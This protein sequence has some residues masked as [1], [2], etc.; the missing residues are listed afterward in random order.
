MK[1][2]GAERGGGVRLQG[3]GD[4]LFF[5]SDSKYLLVAEGV[6]KPRGGKSLACNCAIMLDTRYK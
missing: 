6:S 4:A 5:I 3:K 2:S 1:E